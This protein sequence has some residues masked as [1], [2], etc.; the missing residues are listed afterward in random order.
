M[1][2][3]EERFLTSFLKPYLINMKNKKHSREERNPIF[4]QLLE[5]ALDY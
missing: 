1:K 4:L 2:R 5:D 3:K